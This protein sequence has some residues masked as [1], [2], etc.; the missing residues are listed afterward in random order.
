MVSIT[1]LLLTYFI[2]GGDGVGILSPTAF[3]IMASLGAMWI[4]ERSYNR[5]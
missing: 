3:G 2:T 5:Q 4:L 1:V